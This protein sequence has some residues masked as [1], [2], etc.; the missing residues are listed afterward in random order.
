[1]AVLE[2]NPGERSAAI[3]R[4]RESKMQAE[5]QQLIQ[6]RVD[7]REWVENVAEYEALKR[8]KKTPSAIRVPWIDHGSSSDAQSTR[9]ANL[10]TIK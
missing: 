10:R 4:L 1:V 8:L 3:Q 6:G 9:S 7:G 5:R 2:R